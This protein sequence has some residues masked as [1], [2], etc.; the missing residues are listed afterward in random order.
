[1]STSVSRIDFLAEAQAGRTFPLTCDGS[2]WMPVRGTNPNPS[3]LAL[4]SEACVNSMVC[5]LFI[6]KLPKFSI[7]KISSEQPVMIC[8]EKLKMHSPAS[9]G[10]IEYLFC[11]NFWS[12]G[13]WVIR[14]SLKSMREP[15]G[16]NWL[17][18]D[19]LA[20]VLITAKDPRPETKRFPL[21]RRRVFMSL[22][23]SK[24]KL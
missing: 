13:S 8:R 11:R 16:H 1:M 20:G 21:S 24:G 3:G 6:W 14:S 9:S 19:F 22:G 23:R 5:R 18:P 17:A 15:G 7:G 4:R 10:E 2:W 12:K